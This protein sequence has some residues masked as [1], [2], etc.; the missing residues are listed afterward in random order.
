ML[1]FFPYCELPK[2]NVVEPNAPSNESPKAKD[3]TAV[4]GRNAYS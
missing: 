2:E 3:P 1:S 4:V